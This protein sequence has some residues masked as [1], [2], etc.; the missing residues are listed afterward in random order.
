MRKPYGANHMIKANLLKGVM[1]NLTR[2]R[3]G[4]FLLVKTINLKLN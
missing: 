4:E 1:V 3:Y 2:R